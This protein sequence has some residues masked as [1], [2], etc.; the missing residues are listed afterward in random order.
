MQDSR[1][2]KEKQTPTEELVSIVAE[3]ALDKKAKDVV[4]LDLQNIPEAIADYFIIC[5]GDSTTQVKAI[6][7]HIAD[8]C[9]KNKFAKVYS[10]EGLKNAQWALI[11]L[12]NIIVHVFLNEVREH[13]QL[14]E[15]WSD[16]I[17]TEFN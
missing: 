10:L 1:K 16:A 14:E 4:S 3:L 2:V 9:K 7:D 8:E 12:G 13:Y 11:D 5:H 17:I 15:L 6:A